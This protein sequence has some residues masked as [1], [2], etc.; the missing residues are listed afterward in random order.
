MG[1]RAPRPAPAPAPG[2]ALQSRGCCNGGGVGGTQDP[3]PPGAGGRG[4]GGAAGPRSQ[5]A[6][7][8]AGLPGPSCSAPRRDVRSP[9][10]HCSA[11]AGCRGA[12]LARRLP[13]ARPCGVPLPGPGSPLSPQSS[14]S[15][16]F[17]AAGWARSRER[18]MTPPVLGGHPA[19]TD[20]GGASGGRGRKGGCCSWGARRGRS[21]L[22]VGSR[23][24]APLSSSA[25]HFSFLAAAASSREVLRR[26]R[27]LA[28]AHRA[29]A[30]QGHLFWWG[31][32]WG[33]RGASPSRRGPLCLP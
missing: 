21:P 25:D 33:P 16:G 10:G 24:P 6:G 30:R 26:S 23:A 14:G 15:G 2:P 18:A 22:P 1:G 9:S 8:G 32:S 20:Q 4:A 12:A 5:R 19:G 29:C 31:D 27:P 13:R 7:R 11:A 3:A 17:G 28:A